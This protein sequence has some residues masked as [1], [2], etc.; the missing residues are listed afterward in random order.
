[1]DELF[2]RETADSLI[3]RTDPAGG[4]INVLALELINGNLVTLPAVALE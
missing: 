2:P 3:V 1:M 4:Q